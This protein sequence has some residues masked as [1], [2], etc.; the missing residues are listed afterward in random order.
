MINKEEAVLQVRDL[1]L[2]YGN[3]CE[4]C[5]SWQPMEKNR[6]P[7]CGTVW[8]VRNVSF[9]VYPGEVLGIVG[10]SGSG[11]S[12]V[13][14]SLYFDH[15]V[16]GGSAFLKQYQD[17]KVNVFGASSQQRRYIKNHLMGMV[18]QNPL[19]G[20]RMDYSSAANVAEKIIAAGNRNVAFMDGRTVELLEAVEILTSR[21]AEPPRNFSGGMQQR[22]QISKALANNP[23]LLLLDEVTTGLD[24][25]VQAKVLDLNRNKRSR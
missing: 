3:G 23:G 9:D 14:K 5:R 20:L 4:C 16:T 25:S 7:R 22:V 13:M 11:K 10:E 21:R 24:L 18:Y 17:G 15:E 19:L 2:R 12:S 1:L 8:A 6:C